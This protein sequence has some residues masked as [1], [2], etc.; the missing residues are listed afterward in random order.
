[1]KMELNDLV[2]PISE[3]MQVTEI[4]CLSSYRNSSV[5]SC[6]H[7]VVALHFVVDHP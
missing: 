3:I 4:I 1:M 2:L 6:C 7:I 5:C